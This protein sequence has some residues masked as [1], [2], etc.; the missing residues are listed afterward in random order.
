MNPKVNCEFWVTRMHQCMLIDF[1]KCTSLV[2]D[3]NNEENIH[4]WTQEVYT[5]RP[6]AQF[7]GKPKTALKEK[8]VLNQTLKTYMKEKEESR[9]RP[10]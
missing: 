8:I 9:H 2:G 1:N 10:K 5:S 4:V 6:T 7:F 3:V